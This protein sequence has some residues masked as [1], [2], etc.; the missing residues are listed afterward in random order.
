M[1]AVVADRRGRHTLVA[2]RRGVAGEIVA[3]EALIHDRNLQRCGRVRGGEVAA[4]HQRHSKGL[5]ISVAHP[6]NL[7]VEFVVVRPEMVAVLVDNHVARAIIVKEIGIVGGGD[8]AHA[9]E[10]GGGIENPLLD[11]R[12]RGR[13]VARHLR[14]QIERQQVVGSESRIDVVQVLNGADEQARRPQ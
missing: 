13:S 2:K 1:T 5:K 9:G 6:R 14:I 10:S 3:R 11:G 4:R 7:D 12:N 8:T